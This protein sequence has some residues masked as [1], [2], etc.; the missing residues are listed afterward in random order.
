MC[1][2]ESGE[3]LVG[4][5]GI[6][7]SDNTLGIHLPAHLESAAQNLEKEVSE[8]VESLIQDGEFSEE[9]VRF[10]KNFILPASSGALVASDELLE[11]LRRT[12]QIWDV[13]LKPREIT[14]HRKVL[15]PFIVGIKRLIYP[16]LSFFLE[17]TLRQQRD[18]NAAVLRCLVELAHEQRKGNPDNAE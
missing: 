3:S 14:S 5:N 6:E 17:D 2:R 1:M 13:S 12:A 9:N 4:N 10:V 18:F 16:V 7:D 11:R 15:G 8:G